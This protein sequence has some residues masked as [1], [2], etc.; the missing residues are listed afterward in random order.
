MK[1]YTSK[2]FKFIVVNRSLG[3]MKIDRNSLTSRA[4]NTLCS[5]NQ[6]T[7]IIVIVSSHENCETLYQTSNLQHIYSSLVILCSHITCNDIIVAHL[8]ICIKVQPKS[9]K[10]RGPQN[11]FQFFSR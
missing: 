5:I 10:T 7:N 3:G 1:Y 9:A 2:V 6:S 8:T 11:Q 4:L